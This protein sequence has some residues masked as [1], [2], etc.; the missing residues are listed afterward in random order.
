MNKYVLW[1][2][3]YENILFFFAIVALSSIFRLTNLDLVE[4]KTDEASNLLLATRIFFGHPLPYAGIATSV[5]ILN[6]PF[7]IYLLIPFTLI[8]FDPKT[9]TFL[10]ALINTLSIGFL[11]LI[12]KKYYGKTPAIITSVLIA[13]SPW[14]II[15]SRKIWPPDMVLPLI[16]LCIYSLHKII[17]D[18]KSKFLIV[19][20]VILVLLPQLDLIY[21]FFSFFLM[22]FFL[23]TNRNIY[24]KY[25]IIGIIIG[26]I[27]SLP[28]L[29]YQL[30]NG[31]PDCSL[32]LNVGKKLAPT[33]SLE[34]FLKPLQI[35]SQ[36]NF[37]HL[38][39]DDIYIFANSFPLVYKLKAIFYTE[40]ILIPL[41]LLLFWTKNNKFRFLIY[42]IIATLISYF[43][44][45]I[46]PSMH[47]FAMLIPF[48][49]M[50]LGFSLCKLLFINKLFKYLS[51]GL[52]LSI[53]TISIAYNYS[54]FSLVKL[55]GGLSG[56]YGGILGRSYPETIE[57]YSNYKNSKNFQEILFSSYIPSSSLY[58]SASFSQMLYPY[59]DTKNDLR[60]LELQLQ[61]RPDPIVNHKLTAYYA[62]SITRATIDILAQKFKDIPEYKSI[63]NEI[64]NLYLQ[65]NY[66][67]LYT[68]NILRFTFEYPEH[69]KAIENYETDSVYV[70]GNNYLL[71]IN[72]DSNSLTKNEGTSYSTFKADN[73]NYQIEIVNN[74]VENNNDVIDDIIASF[75]IK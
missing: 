4:F 47:Y 32:A 51:Y 44:F 13:F 19:L 65:K 66:K 34:I 72:K 73:E 14:S 64:L 20:T 37:R 68:N 28:Y 41:G 38:F 12:I 31:C 55:K 16:V 67:R 11:F 70:S 63:Y 58:N 53:I 56:D 46:L 9:I 5:G 62:M 25:I 75:R 1:A 7:F 61:Q 48:V 8:S 69:W 36:G 59:K 18:Q 26:S 60:N 2:K 50:F 40:Y 43:A 24:K 52:L 42:A 27:P 10:I 54:F 23:L 33:N 21:I 45:H 29:I 15:L 30:L 6:P 17:I 39:G 74:N 3:K 49:F 57:K 71:I 35:A 22:L